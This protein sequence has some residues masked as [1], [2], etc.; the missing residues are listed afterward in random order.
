M[1]DA[2]YRPPKVKRQKHEERYEATRPN[3]LWHLDFL[4]RYINRHKTYVLIVLDDY[5]RYVVGAGVSDAERAHVVIDT[6]EDAV[7]VAASLVSAGARS[8]Y[9]LALRTTGGRDWVSA[10]KRS[11]PCWGK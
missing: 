8:R 2:G 11:P 4:T 7:A 5:S 9:P 10:S 3:H 1:I 6:F